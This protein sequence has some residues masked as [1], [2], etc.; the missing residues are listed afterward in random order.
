MIYI[1]FQQTWFL[2]M[3]VGVLP[4]EEELRGSQL[5][6]AALFFVFLMGDLSHF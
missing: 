6:L 3:A 4:R 2:S 1:S 5:G